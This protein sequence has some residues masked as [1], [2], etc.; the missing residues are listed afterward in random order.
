MAIAAYYNPTSFPKE[1]LRIPTS[2][3]QQLLLNQGEKKKQSFLP[4][5]SIQ[6]SLILTRQVWETAK[7]CGSSHSR[8]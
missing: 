8:K 2:T 5:I 6:M 7:E 4:C 1:L 3:S